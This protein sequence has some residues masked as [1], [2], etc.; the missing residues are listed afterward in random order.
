MSVPGVLAL[1]HFVWWHS[2]RI[3]A[4]GHIVF[5]TF[6]SMAFKERGI[7]AFTSLLCGL[8]HDMITFF[9]STDQTEAPRRKGSLDWNI[10]IVEN[11]D[12]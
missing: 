11:P 5:G 9:M 6:T 4:F 12:D 10:C 7:G 3:H 8:G 2:A 1:L